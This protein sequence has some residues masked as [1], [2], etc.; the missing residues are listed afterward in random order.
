MPFIY[1]SL[2]DFEGCEGGKGTWTDIMDFYPVESGVFGAFGGVVV[3]VDVI[4]WVLDWRWHVAPWSA[5]DVAVAASSGSYGR[6]SRNGLAR[7][8]LDSGS[9][10]GDPADVVELA[11]N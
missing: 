6:R 9:G 1:L 4:P 7:L 3:E 2:R 8:S 10:M 5:R 11:E